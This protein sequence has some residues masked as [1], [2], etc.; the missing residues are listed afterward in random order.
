MSILRKRKWWHRFVSKKVIAVFVLFLCV[1]LSFSVF[2][3]FVVE[4]E[5]SLR[6]EQTQSEYEDLQ[7]R[8]D[9]IEG[10][11]EYLRD[12]RGVEAEIRKHFDVAGEGEQVVVL[13]DDDKSKVTAIPTTTT[14]ERSESSFWSKLIPW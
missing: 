1:W 13:L 14:S 11:V 2:D 12:D 7:D 6:L 3:R 9:L 5:V 8:R 10:K 4:R